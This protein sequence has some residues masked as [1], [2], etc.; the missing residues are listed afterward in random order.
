MPPPV[1]IIT[2]SPS[3]TSATVT[4]TLPSLPE[5]HALFAIVRVE[6]SFKRNGF[7]GSSSQL[8]QQ[9]NSSPSVEF[10]LKGLSPGTEYKLKVRCANKNGF[11]EWKSGISFFTLTEEKEQKTEALLQEGDVVVT[12]Y[13]PH[14]STRKVGVSGGDGDKSLDTHGSI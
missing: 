9:V 7:L 2:V 4:V 13:Q 12:R 5:A 11:G 1:R 8:V 14:T 3:H 10:V 6:L